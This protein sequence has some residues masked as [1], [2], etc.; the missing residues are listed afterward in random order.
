VGKEN[1]EPRDLRNLEYPLPLNRPQGRIEDSLEA[2][3]S[4]V[5]YTVTLARCQEGALLLGDQAEALQLIVT[6]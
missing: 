4:M 1:D 3:R 5:L 6:C 2:W